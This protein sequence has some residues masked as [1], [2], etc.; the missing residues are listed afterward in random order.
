MQ[1]RH[2]NH[3]DVTH[4]EL[5]HH[6]NEAFNHGGWEI[7]ALPEPDEG[8]TLR[9]EDGTTFS[10]LE[11]EVDRRSF[12]PSFHEVMVRKAQEARGNA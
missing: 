2:A 11:S 7:R 6:L 9:H 10:V 3:P 5:T 8:W 4:E 12:M 1:R